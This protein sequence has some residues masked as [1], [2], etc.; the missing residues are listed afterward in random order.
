[1]D[2]HTGRHPLE[3][4][5]SL[6]QRPLYRQVALDGA[7]KHWQDDFVA[8]AKSSA[9]LTWDVATVMS[10]LSQGYAFGDRTLFEEIRRRPW[11]SGLDD[12][13]NVIESAIPP[14]GR[15]WMT[16]GDAAVELLSRLEDELEE[17][18]RPFAEVYLLLSGGLDSRIVSGVVRRLLNSGRLEANVVALTWGQNQS[19]DVV[20]GKETA[21]KLGFPWRQIELNASS[22]QSNIGLCASHLGASVSP[23][24]LH[25][26]DWIVE[27][28]PSDSLVLAGSYG[29]SVG[30]SEFSRRTVLE[31]QPMQPL[32]FFQLLKHD[33]V[34]EASEQL[35]L[36][37]E[38]V[39]R[40]VGDQPQY[41]HCEHEQQCHYMRGVI[42]QTM[43]VIN[44]KAN[45]YQAFTSP[46]VYGFMWGLH[47]AAR[48]D[49][50]YTNLLGKIG[51]GLQS[52]PWARNNLSP[53]GT[54]RDRNSLHKN[55]HDYSNWTRAYVLQHLE[56]FGRE[57]YLQTF[58]NLGFLDP[59]QFGL[60]VNRIINP[61][62]H[63]KALGLQPH[64]VFLWLESLKA[65]IQ[66]LGQQPAL[67][68]SPRAQPLEPLKVKSS[69]RSRL[70][71]ILS[72]QPRAR[73]LVGSARR[74]LLRKSSLIRYPVED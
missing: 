14:H 15:M 34:Q 50:I 21:E 71:T 66:R 18:C 68:V 54:R 33:F 8:V 42:A 16:P 17:A 2:T 49:A 63:F 65:L 72:A 43:S 31:L 24:N 28:V 13:G 29:D 62:S 40:R 1:M 20:I 3:S 4:S 26:M 57:E 47:P 74:Y 38:R 69:L 56:L 37:I 55:Y 60:L 22:M 19:R 41:V 73:A 46:E 11:L 51:F 45:I 53:D 52:I 58:A 23:I 59:D 64:G 7:V 39:Q 10:T 67:C 30:R 25:R 9:T 36:E 70:R 6:F 48:T 12:C 61:D 5:L 32:N 44:H 35:R 27:N